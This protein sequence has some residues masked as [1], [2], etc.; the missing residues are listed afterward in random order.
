[1]DNLIL[2]ALVSEARERLVG[3]PVWRVGEPLPETLVLLFDDPDRSR[4][5]VS[6]S[7]ALT[8]L[9]LT[10]A[11]PDARREPA[12][13]GF[14]SLVSHHL[15]G[16]ILAAL[17][18]DPAERIVRLRFAG[19]SGPGK[20]LVAELL[21]RSSNALLLDPAD[22]IL[23]AQRRMKS[24]FRR[25]DTGAAYE[26]PSTALLQC[27]MRMLSVCITRYVE[28]SSDEGSAP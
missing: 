2:E 6:A 13:G 21:G 7:P 14:A 3:H 28:S 19:A 26:P 18:K 8:R 25:P 1:M 12:P 15:S 17:E 9:H 5:L 4:L 27:S 23:G 22:R 20:S 10:R 24:D 11:R 16:A